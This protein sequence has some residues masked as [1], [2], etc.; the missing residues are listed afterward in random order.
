MSEIR[1]HDRIKIADFD[2]EQTRQANSGAMRYK[3][4]KNE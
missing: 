4:E 1:S 3:K 2:R